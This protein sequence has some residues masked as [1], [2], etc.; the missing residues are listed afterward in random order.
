MDGNMKKRLTFL[1]II[2][3]ALLLAGCNMPASQNPTEPTDDSMATEI[4]KI[5]T[6]TPVEVLITPTVSV[7]QDETEAPTDAV[8]TE[9]PTEEPVEDTATP[10]PTAT[11]TQAP[12]ATLSDTDP[13]ASLG[14]PSWVDNLDNGNNW[15]T[16]N[17][18]FTHIKFENGYMK[19]TAV[20]DLDGWRLPWPTIEDF[21]LEG[22]FQTP[23]CSGTDHYGLVFRSPKDSKTGQSYLFGITCDGKYSLRIW[24]DPDMTVPIGWTSSDKILK[25][26]DEVN[27]LGV[28]ARGDTLTFYINGSKVD[29]VTD[30]T[31]SEGAFGVFVG[32]DSGADFTMW[33]DQ[34]RYWIV[35]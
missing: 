30:D 16:D 11:S 15:A 29:E 25:G 31:F 3:I 32:G 26:A 10:T 23:S 22:K 24:D 9:A 6:G 13:A 21:Y 14:S 34:I 2:I 19:L 18:Q 20:S 12:T 17:D 7:D 35:D 5:L 33:L 8:E 27:T 4:A 1:S 28:M